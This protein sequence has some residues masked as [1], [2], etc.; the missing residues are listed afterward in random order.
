M[1]WNQTTETYLV[2][3]LRLSWIYPVVRAVDIVKALGLM[4]STVSIMLKNFRKKDYIVV[5]R[6]G[7][8]YLTAKGREIAVAVQE[9]HD[10]ALEWLISLG[11]DPAKAEEE[12]CRLQHCFS[13]ETLNIVKE[14]C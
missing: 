6:E 5:T 12:A 1:I 8:I 3:I 9:R 2:T 10:F 13:D 4:K 14:R 7:Y 11:I